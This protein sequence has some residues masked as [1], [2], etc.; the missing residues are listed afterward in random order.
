[1]RRMECIFVNI[2]AAAV[3]AFEFVFDDKIPLTAG[4]RS[5]PVGGSTYW[6]DDGSASH[7]TEFFEGKK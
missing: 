6:I 7:Y 1:M 4:S 2:N 3:A 5:A